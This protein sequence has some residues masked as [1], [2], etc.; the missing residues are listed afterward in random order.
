MV[1]GRHTPAIGSD[2]RCV[3]VLDR[4]RGK[5]EDGLQDTCALALKENLILEVQEQGLATATL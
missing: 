1:K 3:R 4:N 2:W 5:L